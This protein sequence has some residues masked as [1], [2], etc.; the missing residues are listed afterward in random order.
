MK[1][2][3]T[4]MKIIAICG[5]KQTGKDLVANT[6]ITKLNENGIATR[7]LHFGD[8]TKPLIKQTFNLRDDKEYYDFCR[9][10]HTIM[11]KPVSGKQIV[12]TLQGKLRH[13]NGN[14]SIDHIE[15]EIYAYKGFHREELDT[16]VLIITD[17]RF[18]EELKWCKANNIKVVKVKR[19][20]GIVD[21]TIDERD[22]DDFLCDV[23]VDNNGDEKDL[24][25]EIIKKL[26][27]MI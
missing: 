1:E 12:K 10:I 25:Q 17:L 23:I 24:E 21:P 8:F 20:S 7:K 2:K 11:G 22:I 18:K 15:S 27:D 9:Q 16:S 13:N 6:I 3:E 14:L 5:Q 4:I 26:P 19:D